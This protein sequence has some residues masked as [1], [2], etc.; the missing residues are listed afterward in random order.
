MIYKLKTTSIA[1]QRIE[2]GR[3]DDDDDDDDI[4]DISDE[5]EVDDN[6]SV[7]DNKG[8]SLRNNPFNRE[9]VSNS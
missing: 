7:D 8:P 3:D 6:F 5:W 1:N 2:L 9:C 4:D